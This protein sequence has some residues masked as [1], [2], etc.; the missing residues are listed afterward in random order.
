MNERV[1]T[2][3]EVQYTWEENSLTATQ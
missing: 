1:Y 2:S 3:E